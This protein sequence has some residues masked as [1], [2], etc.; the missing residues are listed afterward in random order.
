MT[1]AV[2]WLL[3]PDRAVWVIFMHNSL[4]FAENGVKNK[5]HPVTSSSAG[6][7][8]LLMRKVRGEGPDWLKQAVMQITMHYSDMQKSISEHTT[9]QTS[10]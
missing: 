4:Q 10:L 9:H 8:V 1:L 6:K 3:V 7:N 2:E 5:K